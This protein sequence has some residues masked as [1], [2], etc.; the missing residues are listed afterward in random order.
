MAGLDLSE[1]Q[2]GKIREALHTTVP[3]LSEEE[4]AEYQAAD[5]RR[6]CCKNHQR[7]MMDMRAHIAVQLRLPF[8]RAC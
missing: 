1:E 8:Q 7:D 2:S 3:Q 6:L 4:A 5:E